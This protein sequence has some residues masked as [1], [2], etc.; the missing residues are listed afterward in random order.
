MLEGNFSGVC[1]SEGLSSTPGGVGIA[2]DDDPVESIRLEDYDC[3]NLL[4]NDRPTLR[5]EQRG[6][7]G[8][9]L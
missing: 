2:D 9:G 3:R 4:Q 6:L 8:G 7:G 1:L 5:A